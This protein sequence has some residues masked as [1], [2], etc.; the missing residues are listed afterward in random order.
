MRRPAIVEFQ[1][2]STPLVHTDATHVS[3][4]LTLSLSLSLSLS[5]LH[6]L[7]FCTT[8]ICAVPSDFVI[9]PHFLT[10]DPG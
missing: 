6:Q 4:S 1:P 8:D 5:L 2:I 10:S 7:A 9:Q 3:L